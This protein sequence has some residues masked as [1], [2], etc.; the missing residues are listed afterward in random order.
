MKLAWPHHP[1]ALW[2]IAATV[3]EATTV[4]TGYYDRVEETIP[5]NAMLGTSQEIVQEP[6]PLEDRGDR[7]TV[8]CVINLE[9]TM[10][11]VAWAASLSKEFPEADSWVVRVRTL[12]SRENLRIRI[13]G[14][15]MI[16][17]NIT[18]VRNAAGEASIIMTS[19]SGCSQPM[20]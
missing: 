19:A 3:E 11:R 1:N 18:A 4:V 15:T 9:P 17:L 20:K 7:A 10:D 13:V 8:R 6:C 12:D 16:I 5:A 2:A 14:K